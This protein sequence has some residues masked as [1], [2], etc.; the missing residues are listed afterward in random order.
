MINY[1]EGFWDLNFDIWNPGLETQHKKVTGF[2]LT[3]SLKNFK[4]LRKRKKRGSLIFS[5]ISLLNF[6]T[7]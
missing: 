2:S 3:I 5:P 7:F 1:D 6:F 4:V